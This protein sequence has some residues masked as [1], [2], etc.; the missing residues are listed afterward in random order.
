MLLSY[1]CRIVTA[2]QALLLLVV[3]PL[4]IVTITL[5]T[6]H[7]V[8]GTMSLD[9]MT[10]TEVISAVQ[11][12]VIYALIDHFLYNNYIVYIACLTQFPIWLMM[13][14]VVFMNV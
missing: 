8:T 7:V 9:T 13:W 6:H 2:I 12:A 14:C 11:D 3:S 10:L 4:G 1:T 5:L